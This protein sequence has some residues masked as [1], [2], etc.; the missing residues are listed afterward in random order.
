MIVVTE[1]PRPDVVPLTVTRI[2]H[3][4]VLLNFGGKYVLSFN[5]PIVNA[6]AGWRLNV[7]L[8][9]SERE[10]LPGFMW[11]RSRNRLLRDI[12]LCSHKHWY[13]EGQAS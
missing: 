8:R 6:L 12:P 11:M 10:T 7:G 13:L 4:T 9:K 2:A 1:P 5:L 3:A